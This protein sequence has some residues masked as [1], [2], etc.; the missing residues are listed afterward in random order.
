MNELHR[1]AVVAHDAGG[2]EIL[3][4]YIRRQ[5]VQYQSRCLFVLEGPARKIFATKLGPIDTL[6]IRAAIKQSSTVL[7]GTGWQSELELESIILSRQHG[8]RSTA[9]LDHWVNYKERFIRGGNLHLPDEIWVGDPAAFE[10]AHAVLPDVSITLVENPYFLDIA[11]AFS[12]PAVALSPH[13]GFSIL[14]VCEPVREPARKQHGDE[15]YWGYTEEEALRY[16][17]DNIHVLKEPIARILIRHHPSEA[18]EKYLSIAQEYDLPLH[19]SDGRSL[20]EDIRSSHCVVGC[21]S[22]AMVMGLLAG[23]QVVCCIPP[24]GRPCVLPQLGIEHL[25]TLA[26]SPTRDS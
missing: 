19:F 10:L 22:T 17:L 1:I 6:P 24:G 12:D 16:F 14:Y 5:G 9:F 13:D 15:R 21:N 2:A 7:C 18:A 3:S 11:A 23:R 20:T 8:K 26:M 4:S 25:Q